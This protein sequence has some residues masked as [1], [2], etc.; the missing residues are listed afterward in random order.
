MI[1]IDSFWPIFFLAVALQGFFLSGVLLL[2]KKANRTNAVL[3]VLIILFS[4]SLLDS[5]YF[6]SELYKENPHF[7]GIS[8]D[9]RLIYGPLFYLYLKK[10]TQSGHVSL[11]KNWLIFLPFIIA[12]LWHLPY[13]LSDT[14]EKLDLISNWGR[15]IINAAIL[16]TIG[17]VSLGYFNIKSYQLIKKVEKE[18]TIK[19]IGSKHW[20]GLIFIAYTLFT[21]FHYLHFVNII[22]GNPISLSDIIVAIGHSI[23]I[24]SIG[25]LGL[26][27]SKL[28]NGIQV[29]NT[30][31]KTNS[32]PKK[33]AEEMYHKLKDY[34]VSSEVYKENDVKLADLANQL[35]LTPHQLSQIINQNAGQNFS[36]FINNYRINEAVELIFDIDR[37][38]EL[39][40]EVGFNNRTTFN[41][42]FKKTTGL[43]PTQY[44]KKHKKR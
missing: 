35:S 13:Y 21:L 12:V 28:L 2:Q 14:N 15:S 38:N 17:L 4:L 27:M 1:Q 5:A 34:L 18:K 31:Y 29:D 3:S 11:K 40:Y 23:F 33:F 41:K 24:Y 30:K 9:F 19:I 36:E 10:L 37:V 7:L 6:W 32:I 43:T 8:L 22:I 44:K 42:L 26:K 20:L 39:A 16:P 25:Y